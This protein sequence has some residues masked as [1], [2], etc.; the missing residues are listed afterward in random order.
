VAK[1]T[2]HIAHIARIGVTG[3]IGSG[4]SAVCAVFER[5]GVPVLYADAIA[6]E[7]SDADTAI[8]KKIATLLGPQSYTSNGTLNRTYVASLVF[9]NKKL[10]QQLNAIVHPKVEREIEARIGRLKG[11][12]PFVVV[13]AALIY[14][15]GL[16]ALL[17]AVVVVDAEEDARIRR[18]VKR[19][20]VSAE[21]V[22]KRIGAQWN[23][24]QKLSR[25]DIVI[26]NNGSLSELE[27]QVRF[28][29]TLFIQLYRKA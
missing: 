7:I 3:G 21:D 10:Q 8:K 28:L 26:R 11:S 15:A 24:A 25:A 4:K 17:D 9:S 27:I 6:R 19:D 18:V 2:S 1:R 16:D 20:G 13:E 29:Y 12:P 22:R 14:E 23:Q 5:L